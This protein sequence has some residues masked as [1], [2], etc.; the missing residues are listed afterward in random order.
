MNSEAVD[1]GSQEWF[2]LRLGKV[3]ASKMADVMSK[4]TSRQTYMEKLS[5]ERLTGQSGGA[6]SNTAMEWGTEQEPFARQAYEI[7]KGYFVEETGFWQYSNKDEELELGASPDGL[8]DEDGLVEIKCPNSSTH[9][10]WLRDHKVPTKHIKQIQCQLWVTNREWCDF[11]SYDPRII[12]PENRLMI[13]RCQ[14]DDVLIKSMEEETRK[15]LN[16]LDQLCE[17]IVN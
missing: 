3:T 12:D 11:V 13:I 5:A 16:E 2:D 8:V 17:T 1:Q 10:G 14:R 4:G 9:V 15:F 7:E 6:F